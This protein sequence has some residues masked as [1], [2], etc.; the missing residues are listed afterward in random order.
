MEIVIWVVII[1][2]I[3][4]A[5]HVL[6]HHFRAK[7]PPREFV[8]AAERGGLAEIAEETRAQLDTPATTESIMPTVRKESDHGKV[9]CGDQMPSAAQSSANDVVAW[10]TL[11]I[12]VATLV[13]QITSTLQ[14]PW[15][16]GRVITNP[17]APA[18]EVDYR[19]PTSAS[20]GP[21]GLLSFQLSAIS[22]AVASMGSEEAIAGVG[23]LTY[24]SVGRLRVYCRGRPEAKAVM[25]R[26]N[27]EFYASVAGFRQQVLARIKE[28]P[29]QLRKGE[30]EGWA[31]EFAVSCS[32]SVI[33]VRTAEVAERV[34][35][36]LNEQYHAIVA[37]EVDGVISDLHHLI[38][39]TNTASSGVVGLEET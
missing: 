32:Q 31:P 10:R 2:A 36:K 9:Y 5:V 18:R 14:N 33:L 7:P 38:G 37:S 3:G 1:I 26:I 21:L 35:K 28:L 22:L 16:A 25:E 30:T 19:I 20:P 8:S 15:R 13:R 34:A 12:S 39:A 6:A 24:L 23:T 4:I 11:D 17:E 27:S 29:D